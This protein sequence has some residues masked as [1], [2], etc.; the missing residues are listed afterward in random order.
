M[1]FWINVGIC[2]LWSWVLS[3][4]IASLGDIDAISIGFL[5]NVEISL[6]YAWVSS[7]IIAF[8]GDIYAICIGFLMYVEICLLCAWVLT[9]Q[10]ISTADL[11]TSSPQLVQTGNLEDNLNS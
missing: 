3:F 2:L 1:G 6:L 11:N 10:I 9:Q 4:I 7:F 5:V 8:L